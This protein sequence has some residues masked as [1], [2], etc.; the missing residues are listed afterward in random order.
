M[1]I[2]TL[3]IMLTTQNQELTDQ[4]KAEVIQEIER[5]FTSAS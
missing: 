5:R 4:E 1:D 2:K 3:L